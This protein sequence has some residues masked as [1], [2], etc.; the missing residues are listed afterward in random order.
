M[1]KLFDAMNKFDDNQAKRPKLRTGDKEVHLPRQSIPVKRKKDSSIE[2]KK[3]MP[4]EKSRIVDADIQASSGTSCFGEPDIRAAHTNEKQYVIVNQVQPQRTDESNA[5]K[6]ED[7][8]DRKQINAQLNKLRKEYSNLNIQ[9]I[10]EQK[11]SFFGLSWHRKRKVYLHR[12]PN[13]LISE[14]FN[15]IRSNLLIKIKEKKIRTVLITSVSPSDGKSL[16]AANL[17]QSIAMGLDKFVLLI[18]TDY[19]LPTIHQYFN[20][21]RALG[22]SDY[23]I[24]NTIHFDQIQYKSDIDKLSVIPVGTHYDNSSGIIS[25]RIMKLFVQELK[26]RYDDRIIIF[27]S[28]PIGMADS[29]WMSDLVDGVV[30]VVKSN[31]TDKRSVKKIIDK[32]GK[33]KILGIVVNYYKMAKSEYYPYNYYG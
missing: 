31:K 25:S 26:H 21:E 18:D 22:L 3:I 17:A 27:D 6:E 11:K 32:I 29:L 4:P 23:L 2:K 15:I 14:S 30:L 7:K 13:T 1:G 24:D 28:P 20:I 8:V 16:I 12:K 9:K 5:D 33:T 19:R 10:E